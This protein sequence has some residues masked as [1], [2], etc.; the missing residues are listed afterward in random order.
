M[1]M[2]GFQGERLKILHD[3]MEWKAPKTYAEL[4]E[5]GMLW[6]VLEGR[7]REMMQAWEKELERVEIWKRE[8][9]NLLSQGQDLEFIQRLNRLL[10]TLTEQTLAT[11]TEFTDM[12]EDDE[13]DLYDDDDVENAYELV[14]ALEQEPE[15]EPSM[16]KMFI[17][18]E[19]PNGDKV[20]LPLKNMG[21]GTYEILRD[22]DGPELLRPPK[23]APGKD[24][25]ALVEEG[26]EKLGTIGERSMEKKV[27][28]VTLPDGQRGW[29]PVKSM[30]DGTYKIIRDPSELEQPTP[31]P[32][33]PEKKSEES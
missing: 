4:K 25:D 13:E 20:Q 18:V 8:N 15:A 27:T 11:F 30:P 16:D 23:K 19:T 24:S 21:D 7:E 28:R 9:Q 1:R 26:K 31:E 22:P 33:A 17:T 6:E 14:S 5:A 32:K 29:L 10:S 2:P 12:P 3:A